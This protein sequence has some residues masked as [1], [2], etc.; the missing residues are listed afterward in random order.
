MRGGNEDSFRPG[1]G[2][3]LC[4]VCPAPQALIPVLIPSANEAGW[5]V[6]GGASEL[7]RPWELLCPKPGD[8]GRGGSCSGPWK[9]GSLR[10]A[11]NPGLGLCALELRSELIGTKSLDLI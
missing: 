8:L 10:K 1:S 7:E 9:P 5:R 11:I 3:R 2:C 6:G 4:S